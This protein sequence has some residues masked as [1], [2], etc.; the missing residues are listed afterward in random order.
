MKRALLFF[1]LAL[2]LAAC[3]G[4]T[5]HR[6]EVDLLSFVPEADRSG[7]LVGLGELRI[8]D[9]PAGQPVPVPG[10][11]ALLD[12]RIAF[13]AALENTGTTPATLDLE[14]RMA[15][16]G[17]TDLYDGSGGDL[18]VAQQSLTLGPGEKGTLRLNHELRPGDPAFDLVKGGNFRIGARLTLSGDQVSYTLTQG[19]VVLRLKLFNLIPNP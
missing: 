12:G 8:P 17:D 13:E 11:E 4:H 15:P 14:V 10:A 16:E 2:G 3:S 18:Q 7:E 19:E 6:V 9:D 5:V 1:G